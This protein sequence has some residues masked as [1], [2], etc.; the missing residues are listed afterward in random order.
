M[1]VTPEQKWP[2][3]LRILAASTVTPGWELTFIVR[4]VSLRVMD[5]PRGA[6][7]AA[8]TWFHLLGEPFGAVVHGA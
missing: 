6:K 3:T 2:R 5:R 7:P 8:G 4:Y 1:T